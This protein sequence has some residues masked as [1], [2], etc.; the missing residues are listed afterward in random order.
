MKTGLVLEGGAMRGMFTCGVIDTFMQNGITFDGAIGVSAGAAFG[1]NLKSRQIG[2]AIRYNKKFCTNKNYWSIR[3]LVKTGDLYNADFCYRQLPDELDHFDINTFRENPMEF[4]CTCT[5]A[6]TGKAVYHQCTQGNGDDYQ[7]FRASASIPLASKIVEVGGYK[8]LDG[9]MADSIPLKKFEELGYDKIVVV[10]TQ[11]KTYIKKQVPAL[12]LIKL[13]MKKYPN[14][15]KAIAGRHI[16]YNEETKYVVQKESEGSIIVIRPSQSLNI[17][18][19]TRKADE[20]QRV[21]EEGIK[22][23]SKKLDAIKEFFRQ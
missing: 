17:G 4:W 12:P 22:E 10:L 19:A 16:H 2:R 13:A 20:L 14:M 9:G 11:P 8:L 5:D 21:Y 1:C 3:S 15:Y 23:A 6:E 18:A 7:W